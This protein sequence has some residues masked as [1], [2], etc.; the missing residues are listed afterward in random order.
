MKIDTNKKKNVFNIYIDGGSRGNPGPS[1]IG[2]IIICDGI[3]ILDH[4]EFIGPATN[5]EAEYTAL[6]RALEKAKELNGD[7]LFI[8]SDSQLIV[9]QMTGLYKIKNEKMIP[10]SIKAKKLEKQFDN[11]FYRAIPREQNNLADGLVNKALDKVLKTSK[12]KISSS[13]KVT[14]NP[15]IE[16][17]V[18]CPHCSMQIASMFKFCPYCGKGI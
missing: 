8:F 16:L 9:N 15:K 1:G 13:S 6:I 7:R 3:T 2:V 14:K 11:V 17:D 10:L 18:L 5:N 12:S 4:S